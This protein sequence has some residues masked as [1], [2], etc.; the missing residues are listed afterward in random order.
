MWYHNDKMLNEDAS[1]GGVSVS[2]EKDTKTHSRLV[3][4]DARY[5]DSGNYMCSADNAKPASIAVFVSGKNIFH[6]LVQ[7]RIDT[8]QC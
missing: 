4:T 7:T 2:T 8:R 3:I 1:R 6:I 5:S